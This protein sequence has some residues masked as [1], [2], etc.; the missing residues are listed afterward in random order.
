LID[1]LGGPFEINPPFFQIYLQ[2]RFGPQVGAGLLVSLL[3]TVDKI[4]SFSARLREFLGDVT[5]CGLQKQ[6]ESVCEN[7]GLM[8][9]LL[10]TEPSEHH[11]HQQQ[12][13]APQ[14]AAAAAAG[15]AA[16]AAMPEL[17]PQPQQQ[18]QA[19]IIG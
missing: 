7:I 17:L 4:N 9:F 8:A 18:Q 14:V 11:H 16:T 6:Y 10:Q 2:T 13:Q 19:I 1:R 15:S 12:Q 5:R 3:Q